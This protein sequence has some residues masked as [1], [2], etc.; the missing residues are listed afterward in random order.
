LLYFTGLSYNPSLGQRGASDAPRRRTRRRPHGLVILAVLIVLALSACGGDEKEA[1]A[2]PLPQDEVALRPG[3]YRVEDFEP[4]FSLRVGKGWRTW[5]PQVSDALLLT[6]GK[7]A[8]LVFA[9]IQE[10]Y[11]PSKTGTANVVEAPEDMVGWFQ[12]HPYLRTSK[13]EPVTVGG[14]EGVR[15]DVTTEPLPEDYMGTC[16]TDCVDIFRPSSGGSKDLRAGDKARVTVL[17]NVKGET[18]TI[19]FASRPSEFGEFAPEAQ[20]VVDSVKWRGS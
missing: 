14:A 20:K 12:H 18:V 9:N 2:R 6:W 15:F 13:P 4:S 17:E 7:T 16:G 5:P 19:A 8:V 11:K 10:V 3:E 1:R